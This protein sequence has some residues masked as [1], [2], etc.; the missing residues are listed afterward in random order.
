M[1]PSALKSTECELHLDSESENNKLAQSRNGQIAGIM[2][3]EITQELTSE[4]EP[5]ESLHP[6]KSFETFDDLLCCVSEYEKLSGHKICWDTHTFPGGHKALE[7]L[8]A[9][10]KAKLIQRGKFYCK[11]KKA[12][13]RPFNIQ[14]TAVQKGSVPYSLVIKSDK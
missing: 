5:L 11:L 4:F 7:N 10:S 8:D 9:E 14:F 1:E 2:G 12:C 13:G 3:A 6:G